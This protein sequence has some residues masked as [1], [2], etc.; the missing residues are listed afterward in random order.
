MPQPPLLFKEGNISRHNSFTASMTA[1]ALSGK[2]K[3]HGT[4][5]FR[6]VMVLECNDGD[7]SL[8]SGTALYQKLF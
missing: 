6:D 8:G 3:R 4:S 1:H 2:K 5:K 7:V